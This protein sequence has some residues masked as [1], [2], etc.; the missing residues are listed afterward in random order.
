MTT[1]SIFVFIGRT[2][3][4]QLGYTAWPVTPIAASFLGDVRSNQGLPGCNGD[5]RAAV[6]RFV[7]PRPTDQTG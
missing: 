2:Q 7:G 1:I 5:V 3:T 6:G 4:S